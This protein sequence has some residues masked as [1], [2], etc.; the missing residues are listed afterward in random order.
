MLVNLPWSQN[1]SNEERL[2]SV[3]SEKNSR[4]SMLMDT[5]LHSYVQVPN[6]FD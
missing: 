6:N 2:K 4:T 1:Q 5:L 3:N